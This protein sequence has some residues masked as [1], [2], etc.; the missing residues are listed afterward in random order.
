MN[1][2]AH[3]DSDFPSLKLGYEQVKDVLRDQVELIRDYRNQ[4]IMLFSVSVAVLGISFPLL[5]S[6][7]V[8]KSLWLIAALVP[9]VIFLQVYRYFDRAYR[10]EEMKQITNP[11]T[12]TEEFIELEPAAFYS[13]L[14]QHIADAFEDNEKIIAQKAKELQWLIGLTLAEVSSVVVLVLLFFSFGLL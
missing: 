10:L 7:T 13:D 6:K 2:Q 11:K 9:V 4:A 12:I 5:F 1:N 8:S 14:I 3:R